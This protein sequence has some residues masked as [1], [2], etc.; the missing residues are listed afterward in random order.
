MGDTVAD[1]HDLLEEQ[2][3]RYTVN[4]EFTS[5]V[6]RSLHLQGCEILGCSVLLMHF[7]QLTLIGKP[8]SHRARVRIPRYRHPPL[9]F[10]FSIIDTQLVFLKN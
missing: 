7:S 6:V 9:L 4:Y 10:N 3:D 8:A 2:C 5:L 1:L